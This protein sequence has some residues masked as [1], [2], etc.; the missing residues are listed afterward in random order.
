MNKVTP[1]ALALLLLASTAVE[2]AAQERQVHGRGERPAAS[3]DGGGRRGGGEGG[4]R[5]DHG[6]R[7][8]RPDR[9]DRPQAAQAQP[10]SAGRPEWQGRRGGGDGQ[11]GWNR[12]AGQGHGPRGERPQLAPPQVSQ[13]TMP[14]AMSRPERD[15]RGRGDQP[16]MWT[17][18]R[19]ADAGAREQQRRE[20]QGQ[21]G[22][23]QRQWDRNHDGR[24]DW[25]RNNDGRRDWDN[26]R[27]DDDRRWGGHDNDR[28]WDGRDNRRWDNNDRYRSR[29]RYDRRN[30][31]SIWRPS[32]R[33]RVSIYRPPVGYYHRD[34]RYGD[35][36]PRGWWSPSY[37][38]S[39][40][41]Q[42]DL[43]IPPI[44]YE[45]V[46]VGEDAYLIDTFTGRIV[47]VV[48]DIF[49]W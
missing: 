36:L 39:D 23:A 2:A 25:D 37:Y 35:I 45:W 9:A 41:W 38:I 11:R 28:R 13:P 47:Q 34:W 29:P 43:P 46:R 26:N 30:Y 5:Q 10:P 1:T 33:F 12:D 3:D 48:Y 17:R 32:E 42:Y 14:P 40:W 6:D 16:G 20:W 4:G 27:R 24:R 31:P 21:R 19:P 18:G 22:D 44:G 15:G 7:G 49:W 8:P